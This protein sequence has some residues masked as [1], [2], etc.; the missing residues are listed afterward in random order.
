MLKIAREVRLGLA[1]AIGSAA[2]GDAKLDGAEV[3]PG[4]IAGSGITSEATDD[5]G[6]RAIATEGVDESELDSEQASS[7]DIR[8]Y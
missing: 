4:G 6:D 3:D 5:G 2:G 8:A 1:M 7:K